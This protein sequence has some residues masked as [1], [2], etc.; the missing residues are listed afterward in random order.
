[1]KNRLTEVVAVRFDEETHKLT[2]QVSQVQGIDLINII[3]GK[4]PA[5]L[6]KMKEESEEQKRDEIPYKIEL[7]SE[8]SDIFKSVYQKEREKGESDVN[9]KTLLFLKTKLHDL[10]AEGRP[11][12]WLDVG[13]G[14]GRA[15]D[16][17]DAVTVATRYFWVSR[18]RCRGQLPR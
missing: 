18:H 4:I 9:S 8:I 5:Q 16:V 13:C 10:A 7:E 15:L 14:Y 2:I 3:W 17:L 11:F 6:G 12:R 1:M